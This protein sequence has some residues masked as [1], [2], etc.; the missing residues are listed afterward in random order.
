VTRGAEREGAETRRARRDFLCTAFE[1]QRFQVFSKISSG[2]TFDASR[3][4]LVATFPL[5]RE[6]TISFAAPT[7]M[8]R[9]TLLALWPLAVATADAAPADRTFSSGPAR[10]ALIELFTSEG[11][12]S[13]PPAEKWLGELRADA[14]LWKEFVPVAFHVSYW[15]HLG[16]RDA[17]ASKAFTEREYAHAAA[18]RAASVYTP[19]FVRNGAEWRP[20]DATRPTKASPNEAG[21]LIVTWQP[22][23]Y[24]ARVEYRPTTPAAAE[25]RF[26]VNVALLGGGIVSKVN[27]GENRGRELRHEF[28]ALRLETRALEKSEAGVWTGMV[29]VPP[30]T[31]ILAARRSIAAWVTRPKDLTPLQATGGWIE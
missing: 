31:D 9:F 30:R 19:C 28:V 3:S 4:R 8:T 11:C 18:W 14:G 24:G 13:C 16:W 21:T 22:E 26:E 10:T 7:H 5:R 25:A 23:N 1:R 17:L 6:E 29:A 27:K 15:D 2:H 20:G 12:S